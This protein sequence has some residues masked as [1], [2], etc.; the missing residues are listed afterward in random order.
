M[1]GRMRPKAEY[2]ETKGGHRYLRFFGDTGC[3]ERIAEGLAEHGFK[4]SQKLEIDGLPYWDFTRADIQSVIPK[5]RRMLASRF[6]VELA[7]FSPASAQ[8]N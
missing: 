4:V 8:Y 5:V 3:L 2:N 1:S 6:S 7:A